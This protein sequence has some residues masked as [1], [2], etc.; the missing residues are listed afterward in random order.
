[1]LK[2]QI[3]RAVFA[4]ALAVLG[5]FAMA[6][7]YPSRPIQ[8][9]VPFGTG[10]PSDLLARLLQ[11][12]LSEALGQPIVVEN[13]VG[14]GGTIG[15]AAVVNA[16]P[17]GY[18]LLQV[19]S[20]HAVNAA[21]YDKLPYDSVKSFSPV[22]LLSTA[23]Y[24]IAVNPTVSAK[25]VEELVRD[26]KA[27]PGQLSYASGGIGSGSHITGAMFMS[28]AGIETTHVPYKGL[29]PAFTDL[30][31]GRTQII[32]SPLLPALPY[33]DAG[34]LRAI[35]VSGSERLKSRPELV[36]VSET[37]PGY[38]AMSWDGILAPAGTPKDIIARLNAAYRKVLEIPEI[39]Q[40]FA[41]QAMEPAGGTPEEFGAFLENDIIQFTKVAKSLNIRA[42]NQ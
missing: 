39:R 30:I 24:V 14:A 31:A 16:A 9:I 20:S 17:N 38:R 34:R 41:K 5:S 2:S 26:A 15:T 21:V 1:M 36:A 7:G 37:I 11:P 33:I 22:I 12:R 25:S 32:F 29:G 28:L 8:I 3:V 4:T 19:A 23:P 40:T 27:R 35:A 42:D 10:G 6:Q 13:R 18:M